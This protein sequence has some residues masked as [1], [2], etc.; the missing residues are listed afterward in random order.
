MKKINLMRIFRE[1][2]V[3]FSLSFWFLAIVIF[4]KLTPSD[5][6]CLIFGIIISGVSILLEGYIWRKE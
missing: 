2:L 3:A 5:N 1:I 4:Y 6:V